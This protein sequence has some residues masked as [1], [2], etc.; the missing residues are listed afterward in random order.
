MEAEQVNL[1]IDNL[2]SYSTEVEKISNGKPKRKDMDNFKEYYN[3]FYKQ[4]VEYIKSSKNKAISEKAKELPLLNQL[5]SNFNI[6]SGILIVLMIGPLALVVY[7]YTLNDYN[8]IIYSVLALD[9]VVI[10]FLVRK[11]QTESTKVINVL[12]EIT[13]IVKNLGKLVDDHHKLNNT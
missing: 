12:V 1:L 11:I 9:V 8:A 7:L 4:L 3:K 13:P 10:F 2:K 5:F 6:F